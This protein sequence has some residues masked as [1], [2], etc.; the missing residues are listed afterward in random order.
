MVYAP[1]AAFSKQQKCI[2]CCPCYTAFCPLLV[3]GLFKLVLFLSLINV[4]DS[5]LLSPAK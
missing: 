3:L 2:V 5:R 1:Q 4:Q